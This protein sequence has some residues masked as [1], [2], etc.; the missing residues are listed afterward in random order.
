MKNTKNT[1][2]MYSKYSIEA[3]L[4]NKNRIVYEL[5][6]E[7]KLENYIKSFIKENNI[8][9]ENIIIKVVDK[10]EIKKKIGK[11]AKYQGLA[12]LVEK[13]ILFDISKILKPNIE[14]S[15]IIILDQLNDPNNLGAILR[16]CLAF[17]IRNIIVL[18][19][20]MPEENGL[21]ASAASGSLEKI[22]IISVKNLV[23]TIKKLKKHDWWILGL[24][25]K[26][27][28]NCRNIS[29]INL[30]F[31][32]NALVIGSENHGLRSLVRDSC[33]ILLRIELMG[34]IIDSLNVS[35]ATAIALY[36]LNK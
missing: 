11:L 34:N 2:W 31:K 7:K 1:Y 20:N 5:I 4:L 18:S 33:D 14:K 36:Q 30:S 23:Q 9:I 10:Q 21:I 29:N 15:F 26:P 3:A 16:T 8:K 12:M 6:L 17:N 28:K 35:Q 22:N 24:E 25:S 19:R 27:L 32:K 13:L